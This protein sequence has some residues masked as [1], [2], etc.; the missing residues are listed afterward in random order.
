MFFQKKHPSGL[1]LASASPRRSQLLKRLGLHFEIQPAQVN[2]SDSAIDGPD[3]MVLRNAALKA[4]SLTRRFPDFLILGSDTTVAIDQTVLGK[5][6]DMD[7]ARG[8]LER[9]SGRWHTVYT[10]VS[11]RWVDG[12]Y[13]HEFVES[14]QVHF[15]KLDAAAMDAYLAI[16]NPLDKAGAYGIQE[17]R[18]QIIHSIDGSVENVMG[19]PVQRLEQCLMEQGFD[20]NE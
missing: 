19:L 9:L 18:E 12:K 1:I 5:P 8:M 17:N 2:E 10:A 16:V 3:G 7:E 4:E 20:F 15:K 14:S 6:A 11:L 13:G